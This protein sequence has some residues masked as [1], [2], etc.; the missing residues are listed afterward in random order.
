ME[1]VSPKQ[2]GFAVIMSVGGGVLFPFKMGI[3][4]VGSSIL[5]LARLLRAG[6]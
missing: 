5:N 6:N 3:G 1:L 2:K 4:Y